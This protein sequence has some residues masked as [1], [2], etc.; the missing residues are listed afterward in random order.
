MKE[1]VDSD[2]TP[3]ALQSEVWT[4]RSYRENQYPPTQGD[5]TPWGEERFTPPVAARHLAV[6]NKGEL[7]VTLVELEVFGISKCWHSYMCKCVTLL[8]KNM[9]NYILNVL[10]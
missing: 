1:V 6:H 5:N 4:P 7:G 3:P 8:Y 2:E 10:R 9:P